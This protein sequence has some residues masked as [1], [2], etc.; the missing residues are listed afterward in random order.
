VD[1]QEKIEEIFTAAIDIQDPA[2]RNAFLIRTCGENKTLLEKVNNL[3]HHHDTNS[4][5]DAPALEVTT[6]MEMVSPP[7]ISGETIGRYKLLEKIGEGGM[8]VVYMAQQEQPIRRKVALK[9]IKVGMD[10]KQVIARFEAERQ[11]LALMDHPHIA[12]FLDAGST[13]GGRPYFV[14]ELVKGMSITEYCDRNSLSTKAR[15]DLFILICHAVQHAHQKG[16]IHRD[17]KPS[18]VMVTQRNGSPIPKIIDF[19]IAKA[20]NQR[21]TEKTLF[22]RYAQIIGTPA[23][24]SP[25]QAE[26]GE[27]DIDTRTDIY[28]LGVLLYEL[29][30]GKTPFSEEQLR[31]AGYLEMQRIIREETPTKPSTKLSKLINVGDATLTEIAQHRNVTPDALRRLIQ[32]DLDWIVMKSLDKNRTRRYE[33]ASAFERDIQRYLQSE[34][35]EAHQPSVVY[36][37]QKYL[38]RHRIHVIVTL[39]AV[40]LIGAMITVFTLADKDREQRRVIEQIYR[41]QQVEAKRVEHNRALSQASDAVDKGDRQRALSQVKPLLP[42]PHVGPKARLLYAGILVDDGHIEPAKE[43]LEE[44]FSEDPEIAG[45]AHALMVRL[46]LENQSLNSGAHQKLTEYHK[47][48]VQT[49]LPDTAEA[50][51]LQARTAL[52]VKDRLSALRQTLRCDLEHYDA[53]RLRAYTDSASRNYQRMREDTRVM[54]VIRPQ[55]PLGYSLHA[56][57]LWRLGHGYDALEEI[58]RALELCPTDDPQRMD[59]YEQCC[60]IHMEL[61]EYERVIGVAQEGLAHFPTETKLQAHCFCALTALGQYERATALFQQVAK[62]GR[63]L[64]S[65]FKNHLARHVFDTLKADRSWYPQSS[66]PEGIAYLDMHQATATYRQ[67]TAKGCRFLTEGFSASWSPDGKKMV[68]SLGVPGYSSIAVFDPNSGKTDLL[69]APGKDPRWSPDGQHIA[70]VRDRRVLHAS[71]LAATGYKSEIRAFVQEEVWIIRADGTKPKRLRHGNWPSW[72]Q[73]SKHIYYNFFNDLC[74]VS[75]EDNGPVTQHK[76]ITT[77]R[78]FLPSTSPDGKLAALV[79]NGIL[80]IQDVTSESQF[81]DAEIPPNIVCGQWNP[82]GQQVSLAGGNDPENRSGLW[83]YDLDLQQ[84]TKVLSGPITGAAW[85]QDNTQFVFSLGTPLNETWIVDLDP[86]I[87]VVETLGPGQGLK[88][89]YQEMQTLADMN[90]HLDIVDPRASTSA[91][92]RWFRDLLIRVRQGTPINLGPTVN[93]PKHDHG[94]VSTDGLSLVMDSERSGGQGG[95]DCWMATRPST[96]EPWNAP[97]NLKSINTQVWDGMPVLSDDKL[98][99]WLTSNRSG[100]LGKLDIWVSR[101][102][103]TK[104]PWGAPTNLGPTVNSSYSDG[105]NSITADG[106]ELYIS[107]DRPDLQGNENWD[108]WVSKRAT[109]Q[110]DWSSPVNLGA[111]VNSPALEVNATVSPDSLM[112]FITSTRPGGI[113]GRDIWVTIRPTRDAPWREPINMGPPVNSLGWDQGATISTADSMLY[114]NSWRPDGHKGLDVWQMPIPRLSDYIP[115]SK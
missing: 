54:T 18:N 106:L 29:L 38:Y 101:R 3:L 79:E 14:M 96:A 91:F 105:A 27:L 34:P 70:F 73:D 84:L 78:S 88:E 30:T 24:M 59:L 51:F 57:A 114:F 45:T 100:G 17:I 25:E 82:Q 107:S 64:R 33:T 19:G 58:H 72:N 86:D 6:D 98:T 13:D 23:Y 60:K 2:E 4:F 111:T 39:A 81:H 32:G 44:L 75:I 108:I 109:T 93:T 69:I 85:S 74:T 71:D 110:D 21:L 12:K 46:L 9:I 97:E 49:L 113:G 47:Q 95:F 31:R 20:T 50:H 35:V 42:S 65:Q 63:N 52:T 36:R 89:H 7:E 16:I 41:D 56:A 67:L 22:T 53:C 28:S 99:L 87:S 37:L 48:Q 62:R 10:T 104:D 11:A 15:L 61:G 43:M 55:D 5:L 40:V 112:L 90:Q 102:A 77:Q 8:A 94:L 115:G 1:L 26:F 80:K 103:T 92:D 76:T 83:I 68:L 66:P